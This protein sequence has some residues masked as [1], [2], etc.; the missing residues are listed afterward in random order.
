M[1][2]FTILSKQF[3]ELVGLPPP[4]ED[5]DCL[6]LEVD[7][8]WV[9]VQYRQETDDVVLF[10]LPLAD[11]L[12]EPPMLRRALELAANGRG[13]DG[14]FLGIQDNAFLLSATL[15]MEN[16]TAE[17]LAARLLRLAKASQSVAQA[18]LAA[19][20]EDIAQ[21]QENASQSEEMRNLSTIRV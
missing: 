14:H 18:L 6:D 21:T 10:T 7:S 13:T 5:S 16:L 17:E 15:P 11:Q 3:A 2:P 4:E 12:P 9:T 20:A 19:V 8:R 1:H